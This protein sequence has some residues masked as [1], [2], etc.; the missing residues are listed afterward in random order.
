MAST[1]TTDASTSHEG[2]RPRPEVRHLP[3]QHD[4]AEHRRDHRL[5]P[6]HRVLHPGRLDARTRRSRPMV[7][8]THHLPAADPDRLHRR[9][10]RLRTYRGGVS[11]GGLA[12]ACGDHH[13]GTSAHATMLHRRRRQRPDVPG[14]HDHGP[15]QRA[16]MKKLDA[17]WGRKIRPGFEMLVNN[18]SAGILGGMIGDRSACS[19]SAGPCVQ[20]HRRGSG[21]RRRLPGRQRPAPADLDL[22]RAGQ[23]AV[24][25]Q[26]DQPRRADPARH[27]RGRRG[28][29]V[30]PLPARGQPRP[31]PGPAAGLHAS[32]GGASPRPLP[33]ARRSSSSSAASTRSTSRTC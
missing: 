4:H 2:P 9:Q 29:Q 23:G 10:D 3:V 33:R 28:G 18:F 6:D 14:R 22:H 8:P 21:E 20:A 19:C 7:G 27:R 12:D 25:Q 26:R 1:T 13:G 11:V 32:S 17:L 24:P 16:A 15:A 31:R 5:G 30:D